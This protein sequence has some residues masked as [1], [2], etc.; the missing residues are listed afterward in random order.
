MFSHEAVKKAQADLDRLERATH[1]P[2][3]IET[4]DKVPGLDPS[5]SPAEATKAIN[6]LAVRRDNAIKDEG[7]YFLISKND[8]LNSNVLVRERFA[9]L[10]PKAKRERIGHAFIE[11]FKKNDFDGGL[12]HGVQ[13]IERALEGASVGHKAAEAPGGLPVAARASGRAVDDR[14]WE[15]FC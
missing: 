10:L 7:I 15:R 8:H 5:A 1:I 3:V 2:V 4:I 9:A 6:A 14:P 13:A 12:L 11:G